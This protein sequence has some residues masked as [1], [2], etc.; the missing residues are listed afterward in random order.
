MIETVVRIEGAPRNLAV[1]RE[2][3][4]ELEYYRYCIHTKTQGGIAMKRNRKLVLLLCGLLLL[5]LS[6]TAWA[7]SYEEPRLLASELASVV[8]EKCGATSIQYALM[9]EGVIVLSGSHASPEYPQQINEHTIYGIGS[10]SKTITSAA[11]MLLVDKGLI[12]LDN[13]LVDYIPEFRAQDDRYRDITVRMLLDHSSG[14]MGSNYGSAFLFETIPADD[15]EAFLGYLAMQRLKADPGAFSVYCNDGFTLAQLLIESVS[16]LDF[17]EFLHQELFGPLEMAHTYTPHD[18][19]A[20]DQMAPTFV[21]VDGE[22]VLVRDAISIIGTGGVYSTAEDLVRFASLF[23]ADGDKSL[24]SQESIQAMAEPQYARGLWPEAEQG[25]FSYGLGWDSVAL[26]P[27]SRYEDIPAWNK[28]GDTLLYHSTLTVLPMHNMAMAATAAG[29]TSS[30]LLAILVH[31][32]LLSMLY[33]E[34]MIET[35]H[36]DREPLSPVGIEMPPEL[37]GYSGF[38]ANA[39][40]VFHVRIEPDGTMALFVLGGSEKP[41]HECVYTGTWFWDT[42]GLAA[43]RFVE[44]TNGHTYLESKQYLTIPGL[45]QTLIWHYMAQKIQAAEVDPEVSQAWE[46]RNGVPFYFVNEIHTSQ[47]YFTPSF[48]IALHQE[49]PGYANSNLILDT[50]SA[51]AVVQIPGI[52]GRDLADYFF[53]VENG[54]EF[55]R[56]SNQVA[57]NAHHL[58]LFPEEER[59]LFSIGDSGYAQWYLLDEVHEDKVLTV[60]VPEDA[61]FAVYNEEGIIYYSWI[62]EPR[63]IVLPAEGAI[64]FSGKPGAV[65]HWE[66]RFGS[67]D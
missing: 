44:E 22:S 58:P 40:N 46:A 9:Y 12:S 61:A 43:Y 3:S 47:F 19:F 50:N 6:A 67:D 60:T 35:I 29:P 42:H 5:A 41:V 54:Q 56:F 62:L 45:G 59:G 52:A 27:F 10:T 55:V 49:L 17:T 36:P 4:S 65:F 7:A 24:L 25:I 37:P 66:A 20:R 53:F 11:V 2:E 32:V 1:S 48:R 34:G 63:P 15:W 33:A 23:L 26:Y 18:S 14:L 38:Y 64:V 30:T 13:P 8:V 16:G 51:I 21:M 31:E 57:I 28:G 39:D